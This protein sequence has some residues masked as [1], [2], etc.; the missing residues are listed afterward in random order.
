MNDWD[1]VLC[2]KCHKPFTEKQWD[3]RHTMHEE[4]CAKERGETCSCECD[5]NLHAACCP[6][7]AKPKRK[8]RHPGLLSRLLNP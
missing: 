3:D 7:C 5:I 4:G 8:P 6:L 1:G 2:G